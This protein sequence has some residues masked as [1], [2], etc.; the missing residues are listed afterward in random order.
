[1]VVGGLPVRRRPWI[2]NQ[3]T[4]ARLA[5]VTIA[6]GLALAYDAWEGRGRRMPKALSVF[7][8]N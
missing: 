5:V 4:A 3:R 1:M 2:K 8:P 6:V 7:L